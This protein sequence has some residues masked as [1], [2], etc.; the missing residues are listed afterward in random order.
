MGKWIQEKNQNE[1]KKTS[2][3][4][5]LMCFGSTMSQN[6]CGNGGE[7]ASYHALQEGQKS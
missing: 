4:Q 2:E 7:K 1:L 6:T 3:T 5:C